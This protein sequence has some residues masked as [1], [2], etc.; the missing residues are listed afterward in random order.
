ITVKDGL[1]TLFPSD[2]LRGS[3]KRGPTPAGPSF[4]VTRI[5]VPIASADAGTNVDEVRYS[6]DD[7][8]ETSWSNDRRLG[9]A[10]VRYEFARPAQPT[11]VVIKLTSWR[12]RSYPLRITVDGEEVYRGATPRSL[13][14]VTLPLKPVTG[15]SLKIELIKSAETREGFNITELE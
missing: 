5:A 7:N 8:E 14:Y 11:E 6:F 4:Q 15:K 10:W 13:G 12:Q 9:T 2:S 1:A 3:L